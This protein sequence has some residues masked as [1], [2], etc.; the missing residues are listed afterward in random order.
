M[1][2]YEGR[3]QLDGLIRQAREIGE[4]W[5][6]RFALDNRRLVPRYVTADLWLVP[7]YHRVVPGFDGV[8][9]CAVLKAALRRTEGE[10]A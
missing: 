9:R 3:G 1:R 2:L 6:K 5:D 7:V 8:E 4:R 10:G